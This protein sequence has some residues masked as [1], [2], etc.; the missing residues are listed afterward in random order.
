MFFSS[1]TETKC[2]KFATSVFQKV[3][4]PPAFELYHII[5]VITLLPP[6]FAKEIFEFYYIFNVYSIGLQESVITQKSQY[7]FLLAN[8]VTIHFHTT[9][10]G[11][12]TA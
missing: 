9:D 11:E 5:W 3:T 1:V 12:R 6:G 2:I 8:I 4:P 7:A 10:T